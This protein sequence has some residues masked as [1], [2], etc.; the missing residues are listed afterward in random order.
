M[1]VFFRIFV[2]EMQYIKSIASLILAAL[3][4]VSSTT[5]SVGLHV[6]GGHVHNIAVM[7]KAQPCGMELMAAELG[8]ADEDCA[9]TGG[10]KCCEDRTLSFE[11]TEY[12]YKTPVMVVL[13]DVT[14]VSAVMPSIVSQVTPLQS[15]VSLSHDSYKPPLLHRD[16]TI[17]VQSFLI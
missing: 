9:L 14:T 4:L 3:T 5:F 15:A 17:L 2:Q 8:F 12:Q 6:C 11:G 1:R 13:P 10:M 7:Q 16:V